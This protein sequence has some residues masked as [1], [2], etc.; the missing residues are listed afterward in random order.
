MERLDWK[1]RLLLHLILSQ[2]APNPLQGASGML[3]VAEQAWQL[4]N[5]TRL[6]AFARRSLHFADAS[7]QLTLTTLKSAL[8]TYRSFRE[9]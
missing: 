4:A 2:V 3:A 5:T 7:W 9:R 1:A 6:S 8:R